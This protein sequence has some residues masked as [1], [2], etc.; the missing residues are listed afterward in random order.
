MALWIA[1]ILAEAAV[2]RAE[3]SVL[4]GK[5]ESSQVQ[6]YRRYE[7]GLRHKNYVRSDYESGC[8]KDRYAELSPQSNSERETIRRNLLGRSKCDIPIPKVEPVLPKEKKSLTTSA[9]ESAIA[10]N[11]VVANM[12]EDIARNNSNKLVGKMFKDLEIS[13]VSVGDAQ[14]ERE[15]RLKGVY[16]GAQTE[17]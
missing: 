8:R 6:H 3:R 16:T 5:K 17:D 9:L 7:G 1:A 10:V 4:S 13:L 14:T 12:I 15:S 11:Q 2:A